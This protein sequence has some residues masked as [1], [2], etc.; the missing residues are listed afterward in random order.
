M[1]TSITILY[2]HG[3]PSLIRQR[4]YSRH[5]LTCYSFKLQSVVYGIVALTSLWISFHRVNKRA[6]SLRN[7]GRCVRVYE[8]IAS[9]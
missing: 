2:L 9:N 6:V 1:Y 4:P 8:V 7:K 5:I 3:T